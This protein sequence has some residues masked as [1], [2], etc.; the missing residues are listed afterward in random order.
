[1]KGVTLIGMPGAG[2][3]TIGKML[4]NRL[5]LRFVDLDIF[6]KDRNGRSHADILEK[7]GEARL[8]QLENDYTLTLDLSRTVFSPG[9]SIVY[10]PKAIEKLRKETAVIYLDLPLEEVYRRLGPNLDSRGIVGLREKGLKI[11]FEE[12][13]PL[14]QSFA[15]HTI[16]CWNLSDAE[17]ISK[18]VKFVS[19]EFAKSRTIY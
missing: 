10:S 8:L 18:I 13:T 4:A 17:I 14:Y 7:D 15:H 2:K 11:L 9:G 3:S 1:M 19:T 6:I 5:G 12:R 16:D